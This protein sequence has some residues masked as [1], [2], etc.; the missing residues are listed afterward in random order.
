VAA[1]ALLLIRQDPPA[2]AAP[3]AG[4][5]RADGTGP[6]GTSDG[7][8]SPGTDGLSHPEVDGAAQEE[9]DPE[10]RTGSAEPEVSHSAGD[11][12]GDD[13]A[14]AGDTPS[15]V[16]SP[17]PSAVSP[18]AGTGTA[19]W[20]SECTYYEGNGRTRLGDSGKRVQQ[21]Q[22]MLTER[23]YSVGGSGVDGEFG[24]G[25]ETAVRAFQTDRG[26]ST[27]GVVAHDTWVALR[28]AD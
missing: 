3:E 9:N 19:P 8:T 20:L 10:T 1:V 16:L 6:G 26:L 12:D 21:A 27:D 2:A 4:V 22:C 17:N 18:S 13:D 14:P 24:A 5:T 7:S 23:G 28:S 15:T 11:R 25:T